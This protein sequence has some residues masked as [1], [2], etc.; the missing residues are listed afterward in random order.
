[1]KS[2][3]AIWCY[4]YLDPSEYFSFK[5]YNMLFFFF[6]PC[7][8]CSFQYLVLNPVTKIFMISLGLQWALKLSSYC[9]FLEGLS[10]NCS[11]L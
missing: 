8:P 11:L 2:R 1:M 4:L 10:F 9:I 3:N 7:Y 6:Y 5:Y